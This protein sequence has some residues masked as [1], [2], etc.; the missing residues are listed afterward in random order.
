M[1]DY[2]KKHGFEIGVYS[3]AFGVLLEYL[4]VSKWLIIILYLIS[5]LGGIGMVTAGLTKK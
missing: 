2:F 3:L 4:S 1:I 5:L